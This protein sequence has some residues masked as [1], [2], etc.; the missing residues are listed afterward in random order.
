MVDLL[1]RHI[2]GAGKVGYQTRPPTTPRRRDVVRIAVALPEGIR[3]LTLVPGLKVNLKGN[4]L[5]SL[6]VLTTLQDT[7]L[8]APIIPV[9][10]VDLTF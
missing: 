5:L 1:G 7:G 4:M 2:L 6:N 9:F 10:G 3:K 8:H